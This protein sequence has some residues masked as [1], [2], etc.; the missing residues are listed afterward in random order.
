[1]DKNENR[2]VKEISQEIFTNLCLCAHMAFHGDSDKF[3]EVFYLAV[4]D[5]ENQFNMPLLIDEG[6]V[7][8]Y[9]HISDKTDGINQRFP[10]Q[11]YKLT[12]DAH[13]IFAQPSLYVKSD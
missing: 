7:K 9:L 11:A 6:L 1:M 13:A 12:S 4:A 5:W 10:A 8:R 2:V 3:H